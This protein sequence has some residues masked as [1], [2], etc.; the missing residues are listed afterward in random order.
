MLVVI[1]WRTK[2]GDM[3]MPAPWLNVR[4]FG[5][6]GDGNSHPTGPG[7]EEK[8]G[9]AIQGAIDSTQATKGGSIIIPSGT[10]FISRPIEITQDNVT[11]FGVGPSS[12]I[13]NVGKGSS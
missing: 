8:D 3:H 1:L 4:D 10:Y 6:F 13:Q 11:L 2:K 5:A 12:I 7:G 9:L